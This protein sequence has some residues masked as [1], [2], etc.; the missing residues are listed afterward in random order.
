MQMSLDGFIE[1]PQGEVDWVRSW[2]DPFALLPQIDTCILGRGMFSGYEQYWRAVLAN[3]D[4][5]LALTGRR[6]TPG[7]VAYARFADVATHLVLSTT[8]VKTDWHN[9]HVVSSVDAIRQWK[10]QRGKDMHAVGGASLVSSLVNAGLVDEIR[11]VVQPVILGGGKAM[12]K[13]VVGRHPLRCGE[14]MAQE[15]GTVR[16]R[17][18]LVAG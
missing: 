2:E 18:S 6:P 13:D 4:G 8:G 16:L 1:G 17:Y 15:D 12:F 5:I 7:E 3:P 11:L 10:L 14:A 9:T